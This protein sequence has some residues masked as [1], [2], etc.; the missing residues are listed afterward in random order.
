MLS[1]SVSTVFD[2]DTIGTTAVCS[3]AIWSFAP[4][5]AC[6]LAA[7]AFSNIDKIMANLNSSSSTPQS[8]LSTDLRSSLFTQS[9]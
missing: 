2:G 9:R 7:R 1:P 6:F 4:R 8:G 3:G 5:A